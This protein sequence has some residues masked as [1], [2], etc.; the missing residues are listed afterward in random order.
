M[1][2]RPRTDLHIILEDLCENV[3]FQPPA[4]VQMKYPAI[5]YRREQTDTKFADDS[6]Y[7]QTLQYGLT[8]IS[9]NSDEPIFNLLLALPMCVHETSFPA[10]NLNHDIFNIYF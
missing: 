7:S 6:P 1:A 4:S 5:V 10:D 2:L 8:L 3:Y 9:R